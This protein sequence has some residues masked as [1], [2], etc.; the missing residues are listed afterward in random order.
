MQHEYIRT[1]FCSVFSCADK[2]NNEP[3]KYGTRK[4]SSSGERLFNGMSVMMPLKSQL[5]FGTQ[6]IAEGH[7]TEGA[8][9]AWLF[10]CGRA[11]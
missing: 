7:I 10:D 3:T 4:A 6:S 9:R 2:I 8:G 5:G 11:C 1:I